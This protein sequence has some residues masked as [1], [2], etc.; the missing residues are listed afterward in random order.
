A[1]C[2]S[3]FYS[4][5]TL[6]AKAVPDERRVGAHVDR[7]LPEVA[8]EVQAQ[9]VIACVGAQKQVVSDAR[10]GNARAAHAARVGGFG[11]QVELEQRGWLE[12]DRR[13]VRGG[14]RVP[15]VCIAGKCQLQ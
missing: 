13:E 1:R 10:I 8:F 4:S 3:G 11:R 6:E 9:P 14:K 12:I 15:R 2:A 5:R 7:E